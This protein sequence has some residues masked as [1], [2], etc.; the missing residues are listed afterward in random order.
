MLLREFEEETGYPKT[1]LK[2]IQNLN[3]FEEMFTGSN[4]KSYKHRYYVAYMDHCAVQHKSHQATEVSKV[5]WK[6]YADALETIRP[7]NIE[8]HHITQNVN[9]LLNS[10]RLYQ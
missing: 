3:P 6:E 1:C 7:Y 9:K 5:E 10:N 2:I 4:Y 8:K